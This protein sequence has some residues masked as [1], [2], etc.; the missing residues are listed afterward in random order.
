[1]VWQP[2]DRALDAERMM[3]RNLAL[4]VPCRY[5]AAITGQQCTNRSNGDPL[6]KIPA[7]L[8]RLQDVHA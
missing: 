3:L 4:T 6:H 7:H 8:Y 5:C 2:D 1:M